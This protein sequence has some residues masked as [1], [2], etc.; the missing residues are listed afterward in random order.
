MFFG[1]RIKTIDKLFS[2]MQMHDGSHHVCCL[3][4][5]H[6]H[7]LKDGTKVGK[8]ARDVSLLILSQ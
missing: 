7:L 6:V 4:G 3:C 5:G 1:L 8:A 2:V